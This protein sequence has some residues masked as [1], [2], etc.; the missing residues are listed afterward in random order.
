M[1]TLVLEYVSDFSL[2]RLREL[3]HLCLKLIQLHLLRKYSQRLKQQQQQKKIEHIF[4]AGYDLKIQLRCIDK[5]LH[6]LKYI[7]LI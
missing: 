6:Q 5:R 2:N 4:P 1:K 3:T 7:I